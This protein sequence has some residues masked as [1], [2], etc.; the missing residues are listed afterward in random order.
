MYEIYQP[1]VMGS[2]GRLFAS[3]AHSVHVLDIIRLEILLMQ[4]CRAYQLWMS[5][6]LLERHVGEL[7][8]LCLI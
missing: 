1:Q 2:N 8:L 6:P 3:A 7:S 5:C 4:M